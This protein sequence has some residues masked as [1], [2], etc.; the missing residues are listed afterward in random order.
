[1]NEGDVVVCRDPSGYLLTE[2]KEYTLVEYSPRCAIDGF[3][4][5]AYVTVVDD[6]NRQ[7]MAHANRFTVSKENGHV[8]N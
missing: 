2:G 5:P 3:V 7:V 8:N 4:W 6:R 1:M